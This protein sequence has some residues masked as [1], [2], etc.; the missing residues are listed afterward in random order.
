MIQIIY[1]TPDTDPLD[2]SAPPATIGAAPH[3]EQG[4]G[5]L[6]WFHANVHAYSMAHAI[7]HEGYS[8]SEPMDDIDCRE[9]A[10]I[11]E[12]VAERLGLA[13]SAEFVPFSLSRNAKPDATGKV[14]RSLNWRVSITGRHGRPIVTDYSQG[15]GYA[16]AATVN[17]K[18]WEN[19]RQ[20]SL[21]VKIELEH[22]K[23]A[24]PSV[25]GTAHV[26]ARPINP[27]AF[28]DVLQSLARDS[29]VIDAGSFESWAADFG[30]DTDSRAAE[31]TYRACLDHAVAL[32][33]LIGQHALDELRLIAAF[34]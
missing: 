18:R 15:E 17:P 23:W 2:Q 5:V 32:R 14:W 7:D 27:P 28:G 13:M 12:R 20:K 6:A 4:L 29:D 8:V 19:A 1:R 3:D 33:S 11:L 25:N 16:P 31:A 30:Y 24:Q 34:N 9:V 10:P 26:T 21:A 22:G